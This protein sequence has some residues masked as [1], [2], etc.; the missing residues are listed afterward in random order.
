M[1]EKV[2]AVVTFDEVIYEAPETTAESEGE[3]ESET[4]TET[5]PR[6]R[7]KAPN[8]IQKR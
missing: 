4:E 1:N 6:R 8:N 3:S 5:E 2:W 7:A